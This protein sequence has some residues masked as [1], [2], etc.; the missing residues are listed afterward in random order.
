[1]KNDKNLKTINVKINI[2]NG[3]KE[4]PISAPLYSSLSAITNNFIIKSFKPTSS[5]QPLTFNNV[6]IYPSAEF[7]EL[8]VSYKG[9]NYFQK[10]KPSELEELNNINFKVYEQG[11]IKDNITI[12]RFDYIIEVDE[13]NKIIRFTEDLIIDNSGDFT[14]SPILPQEEIGIKIPISENLEKINPIFNISENNYSIFNNYMLL[15]IF[16]RPGKNYFTFNYFLRPQE[17]P[18]LIRLKTMNNVK[19]TRVIVPD[20]KNKV[21]SNLISKFS[22]RETE[23]GAIKI[24]IKKDIKKNKDLNFKIMGKPNFKKGLISSTQN[25]FIKIKKLDSLLEFG[26]IIFLLLSIIYILIFIKPKKFN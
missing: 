4:A 3:T 25:S 19:E 20:A 6:K 21:V 18:Y 11:N 2:I 17:F 7:Y 15:K 26:G 22:I 10:F 9:V 16:L 8:A 5:T 14:Y 24:G 12:E 13:K 1:M 23:Q